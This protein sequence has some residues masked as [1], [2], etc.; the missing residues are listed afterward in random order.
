MTVTDVTV[1]LEDNYYCYSLMS[2]SPNLD[3][4]AFE[5]SLARH[6]GD[7]NMHICGRRFW[8]SDPCFPM[9]CL[10]KVISVHV[11]SES[12]FRAFV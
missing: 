4:F 8:P 12:L 2:S 9:I 11:N 10:L 5:E 3:Q 1:N 6:Q 7:S